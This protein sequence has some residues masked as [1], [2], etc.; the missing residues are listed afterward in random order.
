LSWPAQATLQ[1]ADDIKGPWVTATGVTSG[2]PVS[3]TVPKR[4][5]RIEY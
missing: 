3:A 5:Y 2:V 1:Q 4:F